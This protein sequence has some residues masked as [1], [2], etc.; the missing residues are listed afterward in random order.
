[1]FVD[2][3][4]FT[5]LYLSYLFVKTDLPILI[6]FSIYYSIYRCFVIL[7]L[8]YDAFIKIFAGK[9]GGR[10]IIGFLFLGIMNILEY[11]FLFAAIYRHKGFAVYSNGDAVKSWVDTVYFSIISQ[12]TVGYGDIYPFSC[13]KLLV[14]IQGILSL[15]TLLIYFTSVMN[16]MDKEEAKR[17]FEKFF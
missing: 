7:S 15:I 9:K 11:C 8:Q 14:F 1:M 12:L 4:A 17:D 3:F 13:G 10:T 16:M 5:T 6:K 2:I